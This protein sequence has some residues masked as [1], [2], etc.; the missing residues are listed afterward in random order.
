MPLVSHLLSGVGTS[1][2]TALSGSSCDCDFTLTSMCLTGMIESY[3]LPFFF[4]FSCF[5]FHSSNS[6]SNSFRRFSYDT[7]GRVSI[8]S[9]LL[10]SS[11]VVSVAI[12]CNS[13]L[14]VSWF[15]SVVSFSQ[16]AIVSLFSEA[17]II[18]ASSALKFS[19]LSVGSVSLP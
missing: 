3:S 6:F 9:V 5:S 17:S 8:V 19:P 1:I 12:Y 7:L 4:A 11:P 14:S 2:S 16:Y 18:N 13:N 15:T 10:T